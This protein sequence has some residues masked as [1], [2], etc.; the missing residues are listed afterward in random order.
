MNQQHERAL[1]IGARGYGHDCLERMSGFS[2]KVLRSLPFPD[3]PS[4][5]NPHIKLDLGG[6]GDQPHVCEAEPQILLPSGFLVFDIVVKAKGGCEFAAKT[7]FNPYFSGPILVM[8][9]GMTPD[10]TVWRF[11]NGA[12]AVC[13]LAQNPWLGSLRFYSQYANAG[14]AQAY[15]LRGKIVV[16]ERGSS[17]GHHM[18]YAMREWNT[19]FR[20]VESRYPV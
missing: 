14:S 19:D 5:F 2:V 11:L 4:G 10:M 17:P 12:E 1:R 13:G 7:R 15:F 6:L 18:A 16:L 20:P 8:H 9:E 3:F